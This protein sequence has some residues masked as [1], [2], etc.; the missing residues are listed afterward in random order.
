MIEIW[1]SLLTPEPDWM[2]LGIFSDFCEEHV[3]VEYNQAAVAL[4]WLIKHEK[5]P[6][7]WH[8]ATLRT[9][10]L[11]TWDWYS[12]KHTGFVTVEKWEHERAILPQEFFVS[13]TTEWAEFETIDESLMWFIDRF[14]YYSAVSK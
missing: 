12:L 13:K 3:V 1:P 5:W 4:R 8:A 14:S 9:P 6:A 7:E 2:A 10:N 11:K